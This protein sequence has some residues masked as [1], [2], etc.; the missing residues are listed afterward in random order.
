LVRRPWPSIISNGLLSQTRLNH[1][2]GQL[3][4]RVP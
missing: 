4:L 3:Q 1:R 2:A